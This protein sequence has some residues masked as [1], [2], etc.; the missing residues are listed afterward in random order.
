MPYDDPDPTDPM[1]LTGVE[2]EVDDPRS[3]REMAECFAEEYVRMGLSPR[4]ILEIFE[5]GEFAGPAL[6]MRRLGR[7]AVLEILL[8]QHLLRGPRG[9]RVQIDQMPGGALSLPVLEQ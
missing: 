4:A 5:S 6:A 2:L 8:E 7:E 1:T 3:I 9:L